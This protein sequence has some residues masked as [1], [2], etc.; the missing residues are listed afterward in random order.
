M[1]GDVCPIRQWA[2]A[3]IQ[4]QS[5][6]SSS[7]CAYAPAPASSSSASSSLPRLARTTTRPPPSATR[8]R[9]LSSPTTATSDLSCSLSRSTSAVWLLASL[10]LRPH[11]IYRIHTRAPCLLSAR[12]L[13]ASRFCAAQSRRT[14]VCAVFI[15]CAPRTRRTI[16]PPA[17]LVLAHRVTHTRLQATSP[18]TQPQPPTPAA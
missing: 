11:E 13:P 17:V 1:A 8:P 18:P 10:A 3:C 7:S 5:S 15:P 12:C 9:Y 2:S 16:T 6:S 4:R 14:F